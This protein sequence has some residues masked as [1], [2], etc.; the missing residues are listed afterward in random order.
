[1]QLCK[2]SSL[3][4]SRA[5]C[6]SQW[7]RRQLQLQQQQQQQQQLRLLAVHA[8]NDINRDS[9]AP[10]PR[11]RAKRIYLIAGEASGD[12]IGAK[13][14]RALERKRVEGDK[15]AQTLELRGVGGCV[16]WCI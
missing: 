3:V 8:Q 2:T 15:R 16:S 6:G 13:V 11:A 7:W 1:M 5:R 4:S 12:A 9:D 10:A 14:L